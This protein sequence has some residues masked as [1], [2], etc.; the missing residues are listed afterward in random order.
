MELENEIREKQLNLSFLIGSKRCIYCF[1][2]TRCKSYVTI[3]I[4]SV[5]F[6]KILNLKSTITHFFLWKHKKISKTSQKNLFSILRRIFCKM[7]FPRIIWTE[8]PQFSLK[9]TGTYLQNI[10]SH[11]TLFFWKISNKILKCQE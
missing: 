9:Y 8:I 10:S 4:Y 5:F 11:L 2:R 1:N 7:K 3:I 6:F